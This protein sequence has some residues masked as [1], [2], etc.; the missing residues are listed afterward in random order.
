MNKQE[1][2]KQADYTFQRGNRE[3]AKKYLTDF[4]AQYP[5]EESAWMLM[6]RIVEEPERKIEC[7]EH[8]LKINSNNSEAK[9]GLAR[10][11]F[12]GKTLPKHGVVGDNP[13]Q[14]PRPYKK[15]L[16]GAGIFALL[17]I[18]F[19]AAS[20][21]VSRNNPQS[22]VAKLFFPATPTL[23]AQNQITGDVASQTR[24]EMS[25]NYPQYAPLV[26]ALIAFAVDSAESGLDG[27]PERPGAKIIAS[28][29]EGAEAKESFESALP[30]SGS[31][32]SAI[33]TEQQITSWLAMEMKNNPDLPLNDVQVYLRDDKIQIWG[34][35]T[36][37]TNS[38]SAL[39]TGNLGIDSNRNPSIEVESV[40]IGTQTF[41][42]M[43]VSQ[44]ES[45]INELLIERINK[46]AP[47]LQI[48][49]VNV[50]IGLITIS[51]MR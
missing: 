1:L 9:I 33:L 16:R 11:K 26:D 30:R 19:S 23:Y 48:M 46:Q 40:Q 12:P 31:L 5:N 20:F 44:M 2:F 13:F 22:T 29:V 45:W 27:A 41:P 15:F 28:D 37:S 21:V 51:G 7:Y 6:A 8:A 34:M 39:I 14:S 47:G 32:S 43:L 49:D 35:V 25:E 24:A 50:T 18:L 4:L 38:T 3:L 42:D 10:T 17:A 36:G